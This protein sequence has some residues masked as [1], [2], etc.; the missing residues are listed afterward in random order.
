MFSTLLSTNYATDCREIFRDLFLC[1]TDLLF[2]IKV[3][4]KVC[5]T[6]SSKA[7]L[8]RKGWCLAITFNTPNNTPI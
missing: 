2:D 5:T 8:V 4:I 3:N 7:V 1:I 6:E